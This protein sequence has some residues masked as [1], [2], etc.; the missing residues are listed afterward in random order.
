MFDYIIVGAG[1]AGCVLANRLTEDPKT[2]VLLLEAG[3]NDDAQ[4]IHNPNAALELLHSAVDWDYYT[5]EEPH[6]NNRKI[7]WSRGKVL[8]G[9]SST[10]LWHMFA[11]TAM[12]MII[13]KNWETEAGATA[14]SCPISRR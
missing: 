7:H 5:E 14:M 2:S 13:G 6:L 11:V 8:G 12:T 1:S 10:N 9:S 4:E 3:G